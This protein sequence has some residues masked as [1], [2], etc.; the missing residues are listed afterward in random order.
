[1][2]KVAINGRKLPLAP[3][4]GGLAGLIAFAVFM[5]L[6]QTILQTIMVQTRVTTALA[7]ALFAGGLT[8]LLAW[9]LG[10]GTRVRNGEEEAEAF[11]PEP[12]AEAPHYAAPDIFAPEEAV[13]KGP[14]LLGRLRRKK[15]EE[16]IDWDAM[17]TTRRRGVLA[18]AAA[19]EADFVE[20]EQPEEAVDPYAAPVEAYAPPVEAYASAVKAY[21]PPVAPYPPVEG[22]Q[23]AQ[24]FI[25][26]QQIT[27]RP[28][29]QLPD[30]AYE[31]EG[32][33]TGQHA[34]PESYQPE[35][36]HPAVAAL[37]EP[38]ALDP[39]PEAKVIAA[40]R[41]YR[42]GL[43]PE[44]AGTEDWSDPDSFENYGQ[45]HETA[46][47]DVSIH[48][49]PT[50]SWRAAEQQQFAE[51]AADQAEPYEI[52]AFEAQPYQTQ[53]YEAQPYQLPSYQVEPIDERTLAHIHPETPLSD[54]ANAEPVPE[55]AYEADH[56]SAAQEAFEPLAEQAL[57]PGSAVAEAP[58]SA[59]PVETPIE[60]NPAQAPFE[61]A[62]VAELMARLEAGLERRAATSAH[63]AVEGYSPAALSAAIDQ[64]QFATRDPLAHLAD[65]EAE[66]DE[67]LRAA[68]TTLERMNR[69]AAG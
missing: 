47:D 50:L 52:R 59:T 57:E 18:E 31:E 68:L 26:E 38:L 56:R 60:A 46:V 7:A 10:G 13:E 66:V 41:N 67:A 61:T 19:R 6:P 12:V 25:T 8:A 2:S 4:A 65:K 22:Q 14:S 42:D 36:V 23:D 30:W 9:K 55:P 5:V 20:E 43:A 27:A 29:V 34:Q 54:Y 35:P 39:E 37:S 53:P 1:M 15:Q 16:E 17:P 58:H 49:E 69:R 21:A 48:P 40:V 63:G 44:S 28:P 45:T 24:S 62:S 33:L 64:H 51:A 3:L 32:D 11:T